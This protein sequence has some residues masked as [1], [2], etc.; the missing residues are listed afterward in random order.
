MSSAVAALTAVAAGFVSAA[1]PCI[2]P[3]LPGFVASVSTDIAHRRSRVVGTLGFV[4]G[5]SVV[6]AA[7][8]AT[9]STLGNL[10]YDRLGQLQ[11]ASGLVLI[12]LGL[13][14]SGL[15]KLPLLSIERRKE[16]HGPGTP[17][18]ARSMGLGA[19]FALGWTPCVGPVLA[20]ILTK[21]ARD[22]SLGQG[23]VLLLLY[24]MGLAAPFLATAI[25]I[26][27]WA[28][29]RSLLT[30]RAVGMQRISGLTMVVVGVGYVTGLWATLFTA[31][32]R[33][34][35]EWGWPPI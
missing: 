27:R 12:I 25:W 9:A 15:L 32:Q 22:A 23:V 35:T 31:L 21:A 6:F 13:H 34:L 1:S 18:P 2:V 4:G 16:L 24:S 19:A 8:G 33:T 29:V 14:V 7:L 20:S 11:V 28:A 5:F 17:T 10:V 30:R 3:I 26:D